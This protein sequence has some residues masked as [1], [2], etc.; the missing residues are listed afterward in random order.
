MRCAHDF[1][2]FDFIETLFPVLVAD[3]PGV[4]SADFTSSPNFIEHPSDIF[5]SFIF[6]MIVFCA[7]LCGTLAV[8]L[9]TPCHCNYYVVHPGWYTCAVTINTNLV[10]AELLAEGE[11]QVATTG[12]RISP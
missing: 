10:N 5:I 9:V 8:D 1:E 12:K 6:M 3:V 2:L 11:M 4:F 7:D